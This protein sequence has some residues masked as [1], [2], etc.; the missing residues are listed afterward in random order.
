MPTLLLRFTIILEDYSLQTVSRNYGPLFHR[1]LPDGEKDAI[2]L[3]TNDSNAKLK[4]WFERRGFVDNGWIKF[5][6]ARREVDPEIIPMQAILDA[7]PLEGLLEIQELS[8]EQVAPLRENKTGDELYIALGKRV[9]EKLIFPPVSRFLN[10]LRTSYGQHWIR[11][12]EKWDSRKES[13]GNY[14]DMEL[15]LKWSLDGGK[16]WKPFIPDAR[17]QRVTVRVMGPSEFS[18]YLTEED[19]KELAKLTQERFE[20]SFAAFVLVQAHQFFD[21]GNL[22]HA[23]IEGVSALELALNEFI[24]QKLHGSDSLLGAVSKFQELPLRVQVITVA[25]ILGCP[26]QDIEHTIKAIETRNKIV[27]E[28]WNPP[29]DAK[30]ELSGL[31]KTVALLLPGSRFKFPSANPSNMI[32]S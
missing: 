6:Y 11:K 10:I 15:N 21:Q 16:A 7:G 26:L 29:D 22:K 24:R 9:V 4:V 17:I 3:D 14:C 28:G 8:E 19:W 18:E 5:D 23:F 1:W 32:M 2:V 20:P 13:L 25:A 31:L 27:H 12:L 30:V